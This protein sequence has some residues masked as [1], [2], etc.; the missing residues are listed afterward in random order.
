MCIRDRTYYIRGVMQVEGERYERYAIQTHFIERGEE[1]I[2]LVARYV[3]PLYQEGD[4]LAISEK[5]IAMCQDNTVEKQDV[6]LSL[7]AKFLSRFATKT[8]SGIGMDEPYKLQLAIDMKGLPLVLWAIFC[9]GLG[10]VFKKRGVFYKILGQDIAGI[11]GFYTHSAFTRYHNLA[12]LNPRNP[13]KVCDEISTKLGIT[14]MIVD[15]NDI[16]VTILGHSKIL[17]CKSH[18][19]LAALIEDNPAGQDDECTPFILIRDIG[20][21]P[22][23]TYVPIEAIATPI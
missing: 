4:I 5:I 23:E 13:E 19:V 10:K 18:K 9:G 6:R 2:E 17:G 11:D 15:A 8:P 7:W 22:A 21:A 14:C 12:V 20:E 1:Y 16:D 3:S